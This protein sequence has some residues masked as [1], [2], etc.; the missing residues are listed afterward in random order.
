M[1]KIEVVAAII[2]RDQ[3]ILCTQRGP[4][5]YKYISGKFEFPGGKVEPGETKETALKR[6][7]AEELNLEI[8]VGQHFV[9]VTHQYPDFELLMHSYFCKVEDVE[10]MSLSEHVTHRWLLQDEL[11]DLDWAAADVP[12]VAKIQNLPNAVL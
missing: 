4:N 2:V 1:K 11:S 8:S 7:I 9:S 10:V 3:K 5:K 6:E 12:I